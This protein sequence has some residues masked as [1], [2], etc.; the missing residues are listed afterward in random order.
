M[1]RQY[2]L[3]RHQYNT[4]AVVSITYFLHRHHRHFAISVTYCHVSS[5]SPYASWPKPQKPER[6]YK[7]QLTSGCIAD[8]DQEFCVDA[9]ERA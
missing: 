4:I 6:K 1:E 8:W 9:E 2:D 5:I 7:T 3:Y